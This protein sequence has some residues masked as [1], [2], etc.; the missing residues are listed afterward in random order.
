MN[1]CAQFSDLYQRL[2]ASITLYVFQALHFHFYIPFLL[3]SKGDIFE[4]YL[5]SIF[6]VLFILVGHALRRSTFNFIDI[7][8]THT[9]VCVVTGHVCTLQQLIRKPIG[10]G[11]LRDMIEMAKLKTKKFFQ[12]NSKVP[13]WTLFP[14]SENLISF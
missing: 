13:S 12:D 1:I 11:I 14:F 3:C 2:Y 10:F 7:S 8:Y 4:C 5:L 9:C 6:W